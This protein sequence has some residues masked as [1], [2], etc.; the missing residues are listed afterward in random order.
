[1]SLR[2]KLSYVIA[3]V[4]AC[5]CPIAEAETGPQSQTDEIDALAIGFASHAVGAT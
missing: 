5:S 1:M 2:L 4:A 3:P